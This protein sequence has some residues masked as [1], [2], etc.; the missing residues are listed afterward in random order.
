MKSLG[1]L[2]IAAHAILDQLHQLV[3]QLTDV[4]F[5]A[6]ANHL[7]GATIG[8]HL[9][10]TLE[11]FVCFEKG[12]KTGVVNYDQRDHDQALE[13][14]RTAALA[15]LAAINQFLATSPTAQPLLLEVSYAETQEPPVRIA[16]N[17]YRELAYNIEHAVHHMALIKI[18][19]REV[20]PHISVAKNFGVAV[21]TLRHQQVQSALA[22]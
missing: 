16:T 10:H 12:V 22:G 20:A 14:N 21:S 3:F 8:Q 17:Y 6:P 13:T 15:C 5:V 18:G 9:R 2:P 4:E 11:F 1:S 7:H 19:L